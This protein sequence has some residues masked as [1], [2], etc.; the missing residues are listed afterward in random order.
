MV[1]LIGERRVRK[2]LNLILALPRNTLTQEGVANDDELVESLMAGRDED[3]PTPPI[4]MAEFSPEVEA[5]YGVVDRL[6][7]VVSGLVGLGGK[8]PPKIA[9][10]RRPQ[11]AWERIAHKRDVTR[12]ES[13]VNRLLPNGPQ[14]LPEE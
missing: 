13:I 1:D 2:L 7:D 10:L 8:K 14:P 9:A 6:G 5:L 3:A 4:R 12:H 11:T